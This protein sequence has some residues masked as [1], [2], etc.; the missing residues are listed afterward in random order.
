[1]ELYISKEYIEDIL[2]EDEKEIFK[3][4]KGNKGSLDEY[5]KSIKILSTCLEKYHK[6]KVIIIID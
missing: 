5:K 6:E 1:M 2:N 4:L 3:R